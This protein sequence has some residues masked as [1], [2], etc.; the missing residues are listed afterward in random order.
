MNRGLNPESLREA[1][2][3]FEQALTLDKSNVMALAGLAD[4]NSTMIMAYM[5][6]DR[7]ECLAVAESMALKAVALAP[8]GAKAH[9]SLALAYMSTSRIAQAIS[10]YERALALDRNL[11]FA[12]ANIGLAKH[13]AGRS[14]E[15][16]EHVAQA[17]RLSPRDTWLNAWCVTAGVA[18]LSLCRDEHAAVWLGRAIGANR[19]LP[20]AHF[21]LASA[22]A[23]QGK[24]QEAQ[25]AARAGL[26]MDPGFTIS[27]YQNNPLS[28][29]ATYLVQRKRIYEGM[30]AAGLPE[31]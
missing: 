18:S 1:R 17:I 24:M 4:A 11:A 15:T 30:L 7:A 28:E 14:R 27:R 31:N 6:D 25:A 26:A 19:T 12:H 5:T 23:W 20:I 9:A 2:R 29:N 16:E 21:F 13:L 8:D 22:L 3:F 10:E